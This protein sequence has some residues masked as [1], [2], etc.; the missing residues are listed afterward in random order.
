MSKVCCEYQNYK[1]ISLKT[2]IHQF[3][4]YSLAKNKE[5]NK[6]RKVSDKREE[7]KKNT[8]MFGKIA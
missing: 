3:R 2:L 7:I 8:L 4:N 6:P 1:N 5:T